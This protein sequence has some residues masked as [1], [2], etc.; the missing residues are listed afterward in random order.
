M[1]TIKLTLEYDGTAYAGFQRQPNGVTIQEKVEEALRSL[2]GDPDFKI[3]G[4]AGRTDAGVH[5]LG[6]V[7]HFRTAVTIPI[8]R[9]PYA[10]NQR[11][12]A[13]IQA[14]AAELVPDEFHARYWAERKRYVYTFYHAPFPSPLHRLYAYHWGRE[15]DL[16]R[17]REAAA[18]I[19]G[20][21]DFA[22]FRSS[23]GAAKTSVRTVYRLDLAQEGPI[24]RMGIEADGFL[25]NMV[26]IIAGTLLEVGAGRRPLADVAEALR[27]G[28]RTKAGKTLPP[29]GLCLE[30]VWYGSGPKRPSWLPEGETGLDD[31]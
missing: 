11:L 15:L 18:L 4:A 8:D 12:P 23:G 30:R 14:V 1:R 13:D 17:M 6:Q 27:T 19:E 5:A 25:Y 26:R 31:E 9:W 22:A 21:H 2:L 24:I 3:G 16:D 29:H 10:L 7:I 20:Q 28:D